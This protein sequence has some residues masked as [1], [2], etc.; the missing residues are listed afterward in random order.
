V[1]EKRVLRGIVGPKTDEVAGG[2]RRLHNGDLH[3]LY[4]LPNIIRVIISMKMRWVRHV[5]CMG[6]IECIQN[7]CQET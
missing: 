1:F 5:A 3:T 6:E 4:T 2:W 7:F